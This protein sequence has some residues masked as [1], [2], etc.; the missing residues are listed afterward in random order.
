MTENLYQC[1]QN[2]HFCETSFEDLKSAYDSVWIDGLLFKM[3]NEYNM[4]GN[5]VAYIHSQST[6]RKTRVTCNGVNTSWKHGQDNLPQG[7]PD[8][9][10][11]FILLY[12]N[13]NVNKT[14]NN[15]WKKYQIESIEYNEYDEK[16]Q[17][18]NKVFNFDI[19]FKNFAD[20]SGM[21]Q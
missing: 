6:N 19:D 8:S 9:I 21:D 7:M 14:K 13:P 4:D 16:N 12:N 1:F 20:D 11:L 17:Y 10:A 2:G 18:H 3:V 15:N 5:I